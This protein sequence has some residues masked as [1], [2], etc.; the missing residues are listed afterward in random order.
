MKKIVFLAMLL[1]L[2]GPATYRAKAQIP[3]ID[4]IKGAVKKVIK[5]MDLQIQRQQNR[6]IWLQ[7][8]Q[9]TLENAMSKLKL[10]EISEWT[11]QQ[12]KL[13]DD[14]FQELKKVKDLLSTYQKVRDIIARQLELVDEYKRAWNLLKRD[15]HFTAEE[16]SQMYGVYTAILDESLKNIDQL[17]LVTNSFQTQMTDGKRLELIGKSDDAIRRNLIDLRS[18]NRKNFGLSVARATDEKEA[19]MLKKVYGLN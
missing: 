11:E 17:F 10:R 8:A 14:Y 13:Y 2:T 16:L 19:A 1:L 3:V 18:Y 5:A 4:V 12:R 7:N 15:P 6:V 9:K